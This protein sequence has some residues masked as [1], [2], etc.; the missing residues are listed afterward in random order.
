MS[1]EPILPQTLRLSIAHLMLWTLG[2]AIALALFRPYLESQ[3]PRTNEPAVRY[4]QF[5]KGITL[6]LIPFGGASIGALILAAIHRARGGKLFP[7]QPGHWLLIVFA[8]SYFSSALG[9]LLLFTRESVELSRA[10]AA[11]WGFTGLAMMMV[12][13][14]VLP[15][16]LVRDAPRW[17]VLF[18]VEVIR[19][20]ANVVTTGLNAI[21]I[22]SLASGGPSLD[23]LRL[24]SGVTSLLLLAAGVVYLITF[25]REVA[26]RPQRDYLHW[27]GCLTHLAALAIFA[28]QLLAPWLLR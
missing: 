8:M 11:Y 12:A 24:A 1:S 5:Q 20:V 18:V 19:R 15:L 2:T 4:F 7:V 27:V 17:R 28:V 3:S 16:L 10:A 26:V 22:T 9:R 23:Y 25:L 14:Q 21:W 6:A 13:V